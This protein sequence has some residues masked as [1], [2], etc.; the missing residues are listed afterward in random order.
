MKDTIL[1]VKGL[2]KCFTGVK[3]LD[4]VDFDLYTGEVHA[5]LGENGA[6][7]TTLVKILGGVF[8]P[9]E[10]I[11]TV[12]GIPVQFHSTLEA[13][14]AGISI[15]FQELNLISHLTVAQNI[16]IG[17]EPRTS[18]G[19]LDEKKMN[20][21]A[22]QIL[23]LLHLKLDPREPV[24]RLSISQQ[25]MVE[26]AKA[27]SQKSSVLIM[28]EPTSALTEAEIDEL[29]HVIH[30]LR[31][32]GVG[33]LYISH[34]LEELQHIVDRVTVF[35]D[36]RS[37]GTDAFSQLSI[38]EVVTRMVGRK[39]DNLFPRRFNVPTANK[40][41][42]VSHIH[43]EGIL[44]DISFE[45][46]QGEILGIAGL[47]GAGRSELARAIFGADSI[48]RGEVIL[49][50]RKLSI[51][52]PADAIRDGIAY[53]SENRKLEGLAVHMTVSE[54]ITLANMKKVSRPCGIISLDREELEAQKYVQ[55]LSIRTPGLWQAV[56]NLS[57][58]NQ[59]K[60]V[61]A[62]WL[63]CR[64]K[65]L[66]F[67]E[68]TRGIDVGA[69]YAIYELMERLTSQ[70]VGIIMISS[71]L[72]EILGMT[73]RVLVLYEGRLAATLNTNETNQKEILSYASGLGAL[74]NTT[75][76]GAI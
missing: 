5:L 72:P 6:G 75:S 35:R 36:G 11:L 13:Q 10:G 30:T 69:K 33:I 37:I 22:T 18:I 66:I 54:N 55:N 32:Q 8:P 59:Q 39:L 25:Q 1:A 56:V 2:S 51:R 74:K 52:S 48:D 28:D 7:K 12:R 73:D 20:A 40:I 4:R 9:D 17:R 27:L 71:E 19:F 68:P 63:F 47:M 60:V 24:H 38:D 31:N 16:Y 64:S 50:G 61:V 67:D 26:I 45:L 76:K 46:F 41:L 21:D 70:G 49:Y 34:R 57:G 44:G 3:A 14:K 15:I 43:R 29:F 62:K 65:V 53:L 42:E 58:G 23:E